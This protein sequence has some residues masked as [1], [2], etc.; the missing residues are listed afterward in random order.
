ML[1]GANT[2][3]LLEW[4]AESG[5]SLTSID[6]VAWEGDLPDAVK[7]PLEGYKYKR[8]Q[9]EFDDIVVI[10]RYLETVYRSG[11][12]QYWTCLKVR[13]LDYLQSSTFGAFNMYL[14][15]GDHNYFTVL[16]E[17]RLIHTGGKIGDVLL[18]NDVVGTWARKDLYYDPSLIPDEWRD[19]PQQG[20]LTAIEDFLDSVSQKRL[21]WRTGCPYHFRILMRRHNGLG[22]LERVGPQ[23]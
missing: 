20:V 7:R 12:D 4:C 11:L 3:K 13:S 17:L 2:L 19:G 5:A 21:W 8:G 14:I 10:P 23:C 16:N 6:P 22:L 15:D 1:L 18:F 9:K